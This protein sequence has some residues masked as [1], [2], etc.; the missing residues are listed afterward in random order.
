MSTG[1]ASTYDVRIW[2]IHRYAGKRG[3]TYTVKWRVAGK[4]PQRT[5]STVKLAEAFRTELLVAARDGVPFDILTG[6]P[7][8]MR[9]RKVSRTWYEHA[10]AFAAEKWPHISPRHRKGIAETLTHL[11]T[12]LVMTTDRRPPETELRRAL[13]RWA[14]NTTAQGSDVPDE[15]FPAIRWIE[16]RV[17]KP[18][19][20]IAMVAGE[21]AIELHRQR[22]D[23]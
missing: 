18:S 21:A 15:Y 22:D 19:A 4:K 7:V 3:N 20:P 10:M 11:T 2:D 17:R 6:L 1:A 14:F 13:Y 23:R 5:F 12:V 8:T 9:E 16:V